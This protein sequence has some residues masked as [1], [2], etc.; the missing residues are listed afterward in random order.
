MN[1]RRGAYILAF[2]GLLSNPW[3]YLSN[4]ATFLTVLSGFG[5]FCSCLLLSSRPTSSLSQA[6][7]H[8]MT[9]IVKVAP[10]TGVM[11][12]DYLVVRRC[13]IKLEDCYIGDESSVYWYVSSTLDSQFLTRSLMTSMCGARM[14]CRVAST[15]TG[16]STA[17]TGEPSLLGSSASSR[18]CRALS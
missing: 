1:I 14:L 6:W 9:L 13:I 17:S 8:M 3:Q 7:M 16:T 18:R 2:L 11:L 15:D 10:F 5:I 4:A 12:A